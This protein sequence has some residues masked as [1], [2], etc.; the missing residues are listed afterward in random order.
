VAG[1]SLGDYTTS[2]SCKDGNGAGTA[3]A[4]G[5]TDADLD[6]TVAAGADVVCTI[7]NTHK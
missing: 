6:V 7:T 1:T 5:G 4:K 3:I 2:I